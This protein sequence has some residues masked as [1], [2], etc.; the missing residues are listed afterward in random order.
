MRDPTPNQDRDS[1]RHAWRPS[2]AIPL[3]GALVA[4]AGVMVAWSGRTTAPT[5]PS[6]SPSSEVL[7]CWTYAG[8]GPIPEQPW[9]AEDFFEVSCVKPHQFESVQRSDDMRCQEAV[10]ELLGLSEI[11]SWGRTVTADLGPTGCAVGRTAQSDLQTDT[12]RITAADSAIA[13]FG[14]CIEPDDIE[15]YLDGSLPQSGLPCHSGRVLTLN[16]AVREGQEPGDACDSLDVPSGEVRVSTYEEPS[17]SSGLVARCAY[18][19][20]GVGSE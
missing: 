16:I 9:D 12:Y 8:D 6:P 19:L 15:N 2:V 18:T 5:A 7:G 14:S 13:A 1:W 11:L 20:T 3:I 10:Y 4:V 17:T